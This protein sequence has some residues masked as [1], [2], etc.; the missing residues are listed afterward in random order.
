VSRFWEKP[1]P[2]LAR[3]LMERGC[4]WNSFVMVGRV[5]ALLRMT[6]RALPDLSE[7]FAG[8]VPS[9]GTGAERFRIGRLYSTISESNFS[10][11]V[12]ATRSNEL[13]VMRV[14][15]VGWSDLGEPSRVLST[16]PQI[17]ERFKFQV[18]SSRL[19][20]ALRT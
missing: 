16:L 15:E 19:E 12:L 10:N 6:Q 1:N 2:A 5:D 13:A 4:L 17:K 8:L 14:A 9:F 20:P 7:A 3:E 18:S 11:Q